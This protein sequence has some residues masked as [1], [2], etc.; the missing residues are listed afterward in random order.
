MAWYYGVHVSCATIA[1]FYGILIIARDKLGIKKRGREEGRLHGLIH[2]FLWVSKP[3]L[4][5]C[6]LK[7]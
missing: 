1:N 2:P 7:C 4:E 5:N 3:T 6:F